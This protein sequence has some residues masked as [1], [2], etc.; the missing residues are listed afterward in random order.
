MSAELRAFRASEQL[1]AACAAEGLPPRVR[2]LGKQVQ[3]Q[4]DAPV[5]LALV[6]RPFSGKVAVVNGFVGAA[7]L[8]TLDEMPPMILSYGAQASILVTTTSGAELP[9]DDTSLS[10]LDEHDMALI[11]IT[12]PLPL[13]EKITLLTVPLEGN[14]REI[15]SALAWTATQ[16]DVVLWC[17]QTLTADDQ[18]C[19][20]L[21]PKSLRDHAFLAVLRDPPAPGTHDLTRDFRSVHY[22]GTKGAEFRHEK[23]AIDRDALSNLRQALLS[24]VSSGRLEDLE[25]ALIFLDRYMPRRRSLS[26]LAQSREQADPVAIVRAGGVSRMRQ[27][28][29]TLSVL[30]ERARLMAEVMAG[31]DDPQ[32]RA[33]TVLD[34]CTDTLDACLSIAGDAGALSEM[35]T[36][37]TDL[38][39]LMQLE[40]SPA[41]MNDTI[42][43]MVQ[44]RRECEQML[45][46]SFSEDASSGALAGQS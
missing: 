11:R 26:T 9:V 15:G 27:E 30:I 41:A 20:R 1:Q 22:I 17:T 3:Q 44:V 6:G 38:M 25:G 33:T 32:T 46:L 42:A 12:A 28:Q 7:A 45:A 13:L 21:L 10:G 18:T 4:L 35:L 14:D 37:A 31:I 16:A 24:H 43:L 34:H 29:R 19:W 2:A 36:E 39:L 8:P 40:A 23:R 5:R